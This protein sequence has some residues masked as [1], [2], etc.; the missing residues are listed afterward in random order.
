MAQISELELQNIRHLV[1]AAETNAEKYK[2]YANDANDAKVKQFFT[3]SA[4]C[5]TKTRDQLI[6]FLN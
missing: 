1:L 4:D 2:S 5:A 3:Q 6:G